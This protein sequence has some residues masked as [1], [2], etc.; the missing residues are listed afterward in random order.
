MSSVV[1]YLVVALAVSHFATADTGAQESEGD[2]ACRD[3]ASMLQTK[4]TG[5][6]KEHADFGP[7]FSGLGAHGRCSLD[8]YSDH[9]TVDDGTTSHDNEV[10]FDNTNVARFYPCNMCVSEGQPWS[11]DLPIDYLG[12]KGSRIIVKAGRHKTANTAKCF[13]SWQ[14]KPD[15]ESRNMLGL[16]SGSSVP[17]ELNFAIKGTLEFA[18]LEPR[19]SDIACP[20]MSI[21]QGSN[22]GG[23]NWWVGCSGGQ[24]DKDLLSCPCS[25]AKGSVQVIFRQWGGN[26]YGW[27]VD[28]FTSM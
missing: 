6:L 18:I 13:R 5:H 21:G 15:L 23:N 9:T 10:Y 24:V 8:I 14:G 12:G 20:Y 26:N 25:D 2:T 27:T 4:A 22:A 28:A 7:L 16:N 1:P 17:A 11:G 3:D 19:S